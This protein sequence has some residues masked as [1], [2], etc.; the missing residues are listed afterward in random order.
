MKLAAL[1]AAL[2]LAACSTSTVLTVAQVNEKAMSEANDLYVAIATAMN[3]WA[4]AA[5]AQ[6]PAA[7]SIET[8][9][10]ADLM[11]LR[12]LYAAGQT[13]LLTALNADAATASQA[14]GTAIAAPS[15]N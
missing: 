5:P 12:T 15:G 6:A 9:A 13:V 3:A 11:A 1:L 10:W 2:C 14:S 8:K 4:L 7:M